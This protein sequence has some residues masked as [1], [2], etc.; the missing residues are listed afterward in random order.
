M[1]NTEVQCPNC[2]SFAIGLR[3]TSNLYYF[4]AVFANGSPIGFDNPKWVQA[5]RSGQIGAVCS[6]C[7]YEFDVNTPVRRHSFG[8][9]DAPAEKRSVAERMKDLVELRAAGLIT[10]D[11]FQQKRSD[12]LRGV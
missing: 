1:P 3:V 11:E 12:I 5:F 10:E 8:T 4:M 6:T 2:G 9:G 7:R